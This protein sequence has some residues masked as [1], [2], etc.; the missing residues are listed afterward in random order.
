MHLHGAQVYLEVA[1]GD[2]LAGLLA[3]AQ[4]DLDPR[5]QLYDLEGLDYI[6]LRAHAQPL[7]AVIHGVA[8]GDEYNGRAARADVLHQL[9]AAV[10]WQHH[11]KQHQVEDFLFKYVRRLR[12]VIGAV[13]AVAGLRKAQAHKFGYR[14]FVLHDE[15]S[16][17]ALTPCRVRCVQSLFNYTRTCIKFVYF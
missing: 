7:H 16:Y 5:Q 14:L 6:V 10:F 1:A 8:R 11:V 15:D 2:M 9:E 3:A 4:Y 13:A 12:A 17:H